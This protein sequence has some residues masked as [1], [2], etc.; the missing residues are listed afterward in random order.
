MNYCTFLFFR[1]AVM[2]LVMKYCST[3]LEDYAACV[4]N[5]PQTWNTACEEQKQRAASCSSDS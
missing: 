1:E 3:E 2:T 4:A 5:N